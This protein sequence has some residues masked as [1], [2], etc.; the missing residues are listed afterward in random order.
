MLDNGAEQL[1]LKLEQLFHGKEDVISNGRLR[2]CLTAS[3]IVFLSKCFEDTQ[4]HTNS[5]NRII[6][7]LKQCVQSIH[8]LKVVRGPT[9]KFSNVID[10][11][12]FQAV[13][14][15]QI[16]KIAIGYISGFQ[17]LRSR[18]RVLKL[19]RCINEINDIL[20]LCGSDLSTAFT[21]PHLEVAD[22]SCNTINRLDSSLRLLT[23]IRC[24][25]L[26]QNE[27]ITKEDEVSEEE[28]MHL[29]EVSYL[30]L[31][32]NRFT[33]IPSFP[34]NCCSKIT[35]LILR[36]ND[37][38][39]LE[40]IQMLSSLEAL[41]VSANCISEYSC[42]SSLLDLHRLA[43]VCCY[44]NPIFYDKRYR[45][46]VVSCLSP[47]PR[48]VPILLDN[49]ELNDKE[50]F[51]LGQSR[52]IDLTCYLPARP[53]GSPVHMIQNNAESFVSS[54]EYGSTPRT[55]EQKRKKK[56]VTR[57]PPI[58]TM[59]EEPNK[60]KSPAS[61]TLSFNTVE[62]KEE[63]EKL[64][65]V[66][67]DVGEGYLIVHNQE[68]VKKNTPKL[69]IET[70]SELPSASSE[71]EGITTDD[72]DMYQSPESPPF[73]K[74]EKQEILDDEDSGGIFL[75]SIKQPQSTEETTEDLFVLVKDSEIVEKNINL[76]EMSRLDLNG[77]L[78]LNIV[79]DDE[80][81]R[82][83][84]KFAHVHKERKYREYFF[85]DEEQCEN[86]VSILKDY[87][88]EPDLANSIP[89]KQFKCLKCLKCYTT[90]KEISVC[91]VCHSSVV[92]EVTK[93]ET[94]TET[95]KQT[96][97][98][99]EYVTDGHQTN[100]R[101]PDLIPSTVRDALVQPDICISSSD[102]DAGISADAEDTPE[103]DSEYGAL[104]SSIQVKSKKDET[105]DD[106]SLNN[107]SC[108]SPGP[109]I[110]CLIQVKS[111][112]P[113]PAMNISLDS[114]SGPGSHRGLYNRTQESPSASSYSSQSGSETRNSTPVAGKTSSRIHFSLDSCTHCDHH[115][116]LYLE[117]KLFKGGENEEFCCMIKC[118][119]ASYGSSHGKPSLLVISNTIA[120]VCKTSGIESTRPEEWLSIKA[121]YL[122]T[123]LKYIEYGPQSQSFRLEFAEQ[124]GCY[125]F[126][127]G[128]RKR[129]ENFLT[130]LRSFAKKAC[131]DK[132]RFPKIGKANS[133]T[134][135]NIKIQVFGVKDESLMVKGRRLYEQA[136]NFTDPPL[137][138]DRKVWLRTLP[139]SV[140]G[141]ELI[142][143]LIYRKE[144]SSYPEAVQ[145]SQLLLNAGAIRCFNKDCRN[146]EKEQYYY[147][148]L[149]AEVQ[150]DEVSNSSKDNMS[151]SS[152]ANTVIKQYILAYWKDEEKLTQVA[153]IITNS[154]IALAE[155]NHQWPL[156][157]RHH[158]PKVLSGP[159]FV[160]K[161]KQEIIN[162][163]NVEL[164]AESPCEIEIEFLNEDTPE[165]IE[166][167]RWEIILQSENSLTVF[168]DA[169]R[170]LWEHKFG[171]DLP[172]NLSN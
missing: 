72:A 139:K 25:N 159:Q 113:S 93:E 63:L 26:S 57:Q 165:S 89:K 14:I 47:S 32:Y 2:V 16:E 82:L 44:G 156:P 147:F 136:I 34:E 133:Q 76:K 154:Q 50:L 54:G 45:I 39:S 51:S 65:K 38:E 102:K 164:F 116:K 3:V 172:V 160:M 52:E 95:Y 71:L 110:P 150:E 123:D 122:L 111:S 151:E 5:Q 124:F 28:W 114:L 92:V 88:K 146:L 138:K 143:W 135:A 31:G 22:F 66:K 9:Y 10:L 152:E 29:P 144:A 107:G 74:A 161:K 158:P 78:D 155:E 153:L 18:I 162:I 62:T 170:E 157:R 19:E 142:D 132:H 37:L 36:N 126:L 64:E 21:W 55:P 7:Y 106:K 91:A 46:G 8:T 131:G 149:P 59:G 68:Q 42:L 43:S 49:E 81:I 30:D 134:C 115:L 33:K 69:P 56:A 121:C 120:Y 98:K 141:E 140:L 145:I 87:V 58:R 94:E 119:V 105:C 90:R 148:D 109:T 48:Q 112:S 128:D 61:R 169:I 77:L 73:S 15:L 100:I 17:T 99:R 125:K 20:T 11:S 27:L 85:H 137:L 103:E 83:H 84:L 12:H 1:V 41:D 96:R 171:I 23:C 24:L 129:C 104:V 118:P 167:D 60:Q 13:Q 163:T 97:S 70:S 80:K 117:T 130:T 168:L 53:Y 40:G 127:V 101:D 166:D 86:F 108:E 79:R 35:T 75:V 67:R 6:E 4:Q